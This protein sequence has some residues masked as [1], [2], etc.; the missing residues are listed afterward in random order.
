MIPR[1]YLPE[2]LLALALAAGLLHASSL[3][4]GDAEPPC[5][6]RASGELDQAEL[7]GR[8]YACFGAA[9]ANLAYRGEKLDR[10]T[11]LAR[12]ATEDDPVARRELLL[13]LEPVWRSIDGNADTDS[14]WRALNRLHAQRH[15]AAGTSTAAG[16]AALGV[17]P[18]QVEPWLVSVLEAWR[19]GNTDRQLEPW[20]FYF[21]AGAM[22]RALT[23]TLPL[24]ALRP[25]NDRIYRDL[26]ADPAQLGIEYDI[27]P[28]PGK[29]PVAFTDFIMRQR[30]LPDGTWAPGKYRISAA[31]AVGGAGN[32]AEL[33][34]ET[35]HA[36]HIAAIRAQPGL[37]DWPDS[38][39]FTEALA[40][41]VA[42]DLYDPVFQ[43]RYLGAAVP[44]AAARRAKYAGIVLDTAWALFELRMQA[45]PE[46][47]PNRVWS[48][49]T[50]QYLRIRPHP[51]WSWWAMRGQ[52]VS[53]GGYMLNYAL[54]AILI[55]DLRARTKEVFGDQPWGDASWYPRVAERL[56]RFGLERPSR[57]VIEDYLGRPIS[58]AALLRDLGAGR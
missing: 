21:D 20:D 2:H 17:D 51:E 46:Q 5:P 23:G 30:R 41:L 57:Q 35:G 37:V 49:I 39:T 43:Q 8:I 31:Y 3:S 50:E 52:L 25:L 6:V 58:P 32:F 36:I 28:R 16:A 9:A 40:D 55:A 42:L 24:A 44:A 10:L 47:D 22:E 19:D 29:D 54:G 27:A 48:N 14:P 38:D 56:Y 13:A 15:R 18:A 45:D 34:H 12:L 4:A 1:M 7:S 33:L 53:S 26:G 11:V